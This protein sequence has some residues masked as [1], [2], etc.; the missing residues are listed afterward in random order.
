M[1]VMNAMLWG[2][3]SEVLEGFLK[4]VKNIRVTEQQW[5]SS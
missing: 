2:F 1:D 5:P 4:S 3:R